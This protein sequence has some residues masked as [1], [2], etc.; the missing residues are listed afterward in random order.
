MTAVT[1]DGNCQPG[2]RNFAL[3]GPRVIQN[4]FLVIA[5]QFGGPGIRYNSCTAPEK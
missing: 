4:L 2:E 5:L 1:G 3:T